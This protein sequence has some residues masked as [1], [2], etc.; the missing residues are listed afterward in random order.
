MKKAPRLTTR[1]VVVLG[2]ASF[3]LGVLLFAWGNSMDN[4]ASA[5]EADFSTD[6]AI[7]RSLGMVSTQT[8]L[9]SSSRARPS[10]TVIRFESEVEDLRNGGGL[11]MELGGVATLFAFFCIPLGFVVHREQKN[12]A[13][14][15]DTLS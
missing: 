7:Y 8:L 4:Q 10:M 11:L 9:F 6:Y 5:M 15:H 14:Q 13:S 1:A 2:S 3:V 12:W